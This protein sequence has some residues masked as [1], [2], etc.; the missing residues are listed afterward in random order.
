[1]DRPTTKPWTSHLL[2]IFIYVSQSLDCQEQP[3]IYD[4]FIN[5]FGQNFY[6]EY[7]IERHVFTS[8]LANVIESCASLTRLC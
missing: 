2:L 4:Y 8:P 1:M 6:R 5:F 3:Y 7:S